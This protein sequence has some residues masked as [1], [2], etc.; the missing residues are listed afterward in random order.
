[1]SNII[2]AIEIDLQ[3]VLPDVPDI[4]IYAIDGGNS[5]IRWSEAPLIGVDG[6]WLTGMIAK[7]GIGAI[8]HQASTARGGN[9]VTV[10]NV[11]IRFN[12]A[13]QTLSRL[14]SVGVYLNGLEL[15]IIEF[16]GT[17]ADADS[18]EK[19]VMF[20]GAIEDVIADEVFGTISVASSLSRN[21][22][23]NL[24]LIANKNK[25]PYL[26]DS[27]NDETIPVIFGQS[28][29]ANKRFFKAI[30]TLE[31][32]NVLDN[33]YL[34]N[35]SDSE[36][37]FN[38]F[39]LDLSLFPSCLEKNPNYGSGNLDSDYVRLFFGRIAD[40][41]TVDS[42]RFV[43]KYVLCKEGN[44]ENVGQYRKIKSVVYTQLTGE[45]GDETAEITFELEDHFPVPPSGN[46]DFN[47]A[48]Q[49]YFEIVD[50]DSIYTTES[51]SCDGF[52]DNTGEAKLTNEALV[53]YKSNEEVKEVK[54]NNVTIVDKNSI[55]INPR[56]FDNGTQNVKYYE[57]EPVI[58]LYPYNE[59][60]FT[61]FGI[62]ATTA[63]KA[64]AGVWVSNFGLG[65]TLN[66][67]VL[68][69]A[70]SYYDRIST[71]RLEF[72]NE[73]TGYP[74]YWIAFAFKPP[75]IASSRQFKSAFLLMNF[76]SEFIGSTTINETTFRVI[77]R[78]YLG[79][80]EAI[81]DTSQDMEK[82]ITVTNFPDEYYYDDVNTKNFDFYSQQKQIIGASNQAKWTGYKLFDLGVSN[83]SEYNAIHEIMIMV[84]RNDTDANLTY[85]DS[86]R[87]NELAIA[88]ETEAPLH[89]DIYV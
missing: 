82:L 75:K 33:K 51:R 34:F 53:Y 78:R 87:F 22:K 5:V 80:V 48:N 12:N 73:F 9:V 74:K 36:S 63:I 68:T 84:H 81:V 69:G 62:V 65:T 59:T 32:E 37:E 2:Q 45:I 16:V 50:I 23:N 52:Y 44:S 3:T 70:S 83:A 13:K 11:S 60:N 46:I 29:P 76:N 1:M 49:S 58:N 67:T 85:D 21:R 56:V 4:G 18:E 55:Q 42:E 79:G 15:K 28:D 43:G 6:T 66:S 25:Y 20:T 30:K 39:P 47:D 10:G 57:I 27:N 71:T 64:A 24:S 89:G 17:D 86:T 7:N 26:P 35:L 54:I 88:F 38:A 8:T 72:S 61:K 14:E 40:V 77:K 31:K 41:F 19:V